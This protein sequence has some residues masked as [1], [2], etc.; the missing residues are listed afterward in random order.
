MTGIRRAPLIRIAVDAR[1][2]FRA[3]RRGIGKTLAEVY[4]ALARRRPHWEFLLFHQ[5][6][7]P[8]PPLL[9]GLPNIQAVQVD[10]PGGDRFGL[11]ESVRSSRGLSRNR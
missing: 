7:A 10:I 11:W 2:L 1:Q 9:A 4:A 6:P 5:L 8:G 3:N